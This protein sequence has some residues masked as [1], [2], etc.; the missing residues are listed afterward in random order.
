MEG[1]GIATA[2]VDG[3]LAGGIPAEGVEDIGDGLD[4]GKGEGE[5]VALVGE[6]SEHPG[7]ARLAEVEGVTEG[8]L[9]IDVD[10]HGLGAE[11]SAGGME[12]GIDDLLGLE[13]AGGG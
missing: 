12:E 7:A 11:W 9:A 4:T 3:G 13:A 5:A 8:A 10:V 1:G 6:G 2:L